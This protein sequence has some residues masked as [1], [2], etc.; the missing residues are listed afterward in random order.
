MK[1]FYSV[2][3]HAL[4]PPP[5]SQTVTPSRTPPSSVTYFMDD[6]LRAKTFHAVIVLILQFFLLQ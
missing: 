4:G 5:P 1:F 2:T 3:S 6:P